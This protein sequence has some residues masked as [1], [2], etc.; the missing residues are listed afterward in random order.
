MGVLQEDEK[1]KKLEDNFI[2]CQS[3]FLFKKK[4][5]RRATLCIKNGIVCVTQD[6]L[7]C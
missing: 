6:I 5:G 1:T 4:S 3:E 7:A 2:S